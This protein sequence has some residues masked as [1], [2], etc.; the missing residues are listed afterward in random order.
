M[1]AEVVMV[2]ADCVHL[3]TCVQCVPGVFVVL[4]GAINPVHMLL[5]RSHTEPAVMSAT[6]K[7]IMQMIQNV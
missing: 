2:K 5:T 6:Q 1:G 3:I 7:R 4:V